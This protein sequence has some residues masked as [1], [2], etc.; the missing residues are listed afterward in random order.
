M[1][2]E[3][4]KETTFNVAADTIAGLVAEAFYRDPDGLR[5]KAARQINAELNAAVDAA[6]GE[7]DAARLASARAGYPVAAKY[8]TGHEKGEDV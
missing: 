2:S 4:S 6:A 5:R 1:R 8:A 3:S 7:A